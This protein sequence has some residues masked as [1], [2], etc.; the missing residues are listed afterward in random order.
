MDWKLEFV[1]LTMIVQR[2]VSHFSVNLS[3]TLEMSPALMK[4]FVYTSLLVTVTAILG[5]VNIVS[6]ID[7]VLSFHTTIP[8]IALSVYS[9]RQVMRFKHTY[10]HLSLLP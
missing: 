1:R 5:I 8:V 7:A 6:L 9:Y 3:D 4:Q 10:E 2:I